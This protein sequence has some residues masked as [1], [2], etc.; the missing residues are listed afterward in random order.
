MKGYV[1]DYVVVNEKGQHIKFKKDVTL[2]CEIKGRNGGKIFRFS[3]YVLAYYNSELRLNLKSK[4]IADY[5]LDDRSTNE[6]TLFYFHESNLL[7]VRNYLARYD[8]D[9]YRR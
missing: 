4:A 5:V 7:E 1:K 6:E 3:E 8:L 9:V 2:D